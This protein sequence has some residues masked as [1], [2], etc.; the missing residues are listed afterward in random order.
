MGRANGL[1]AGKGGS[2]HLTSVEHG[3]MGSYAIIGAH[4]PIAA[5]AAWSAQYRG[6]GQVAVCFFGD[7]PPTSGLFTRR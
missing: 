4:L 1:M 2:M 5:G 3:M 6:T 7:A